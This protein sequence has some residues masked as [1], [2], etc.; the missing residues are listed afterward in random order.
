MS[1]K[2]F[3]RVFDFFRFS[4]LGWLVLFLTGMLVL[5]FVALCTSCKP[6][7]AT[8]PTFEDVR[9]AEQSID[10]SQP[11]HETIVDPFDTTEITGKM[12][13][14]GYDDLIGR[15]V[16]VNMELAQLEAYLIREY[17]IPAIDD[18]LSRLEDKKTGG[19]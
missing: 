18:S 8:G 4:G 12:I 2:R 10:R 7:P 19:Q 17:A 16:K 11:Y 6:V 1:K 3:S 9:Q 13:D 15:M 5:M 14:E